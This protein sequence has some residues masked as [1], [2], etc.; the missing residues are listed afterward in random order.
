MSAPSPYSIAGERL[1]Q[2]GFSAIPIAPDSKAPG[3]Y[4][5]AKRLENACLREAGIATG[6]QLRS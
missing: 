3:F 4:S 6:F 1:V 2:R 5:H